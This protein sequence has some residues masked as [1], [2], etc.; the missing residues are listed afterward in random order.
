[1]SKTTTLLATGAAAILITGVT[2]AQGGTYSTNWAP[3]HGAPTAVFTGP[4][5]FGTAAG[6]SH[7]AGIG[8]SIRRCYGVDATQGGRNQS[9]GQWENTWFKVSQ[10]FSPQNVV[11]FVDIGVISMHAATDSDLGADICLSPFAASA[12]NTGG[13][14]LAAAAIGGTQAGSAGSPFPIVWEFVFQWLNT[15]LG[16]ATTHGLGASAAGPGTHPLLV[17]VI[18]EVQGPINGGPTNNQYYL[19][20]TSEVTG[21]SPSGSGG[22]T[23]GNN[24][25]GFSTYGMNAEV[26]GAISH[27]RITAATGGG[28]FV[29][30]PLFSA[31][32]GDLEFTNH[33]AFE[34]PVLWASN[35]GN[36][37][38]GGTDFR[39]STSPVSVIDLRL[40]DM[41]SGA[42]TNADI[43][44]KA[45]PA[46]PA[47]AAAIYD[48]NIV[49]NRSYFLWSG[50]SSSG[51]QSPMSWDDLGGVVPP[52]PGS[53]LLGAQV[54]TREG[55]QTIPVNFD[56]LLTTLLPITVLSL[57][58]PFSGA[59]DPGLDG[60]VPNLG[61]GSNSVLWEGMF[62]PIISGISTL[63]GPLPLVGAPTASLAGVKLGV[64]GVGLQVDS[65]VGLFIQN[66][67]FS[68]GLTISLQ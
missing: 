18:Y 58:T 7:F 49:F 9:L 15:S 16:T 21:V 10:A 24:S 53:F 3:M 22:V 26:T 17:N 32:P 60:I 46:P 51:Q 61:G 66:T 63:S 11:Q 67:E 28:G 40:S 36:T 31:T 33:L 13:H 43:Y 42:Q 4:G 5:L 39:V 57:G 52:Q 20:S 27:S 30:G 37:G 6:D 56:A 47:K 12:G 35:D 48:P 54:T 38:A 34:T 2:R 64:A 41:R 14:R 45:S 65:S 19:A 23:N 62:T 68:N 8:D 29:A 59:E 25:F 55:L 44:W 1:M 50:T